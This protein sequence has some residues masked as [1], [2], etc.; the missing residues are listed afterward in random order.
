MDR[1]S[2]ANTWMYANLDA[3]GT[4]YRKKDGTPDIDKIE[5]MLK[6]DITYY[7]YDTYMGA[8]DYNRLRAMLGYPQV[9]VGQDSYLLHVKERLRKQVEGMPEDLRIMD[10]SEKHPLTCAGIY[11]EAFSQNGQNGGDYVI[12][13]PDEVLE[14]MEPYYSCLLYTSK[15]Q[16][17]FAK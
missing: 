17:V 3:F 16:E 6:E 1:S 8:S 15:A 4:M 11:S 13:V 5:E 9:K 10:A 14:R 7:Q 12:V 2:Q